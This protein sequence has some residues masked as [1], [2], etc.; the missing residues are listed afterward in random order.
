MEAGDLDFSGAVPIFRHQ[1][2]TLELRLG[3]ATASLQAEVGAKMEEMRDTFHPELE[4]VIVG[5]R[6][7]AIKSIKNDPGVEEGRIVKIEGVLE[8]FPIPQPG[9][10]LHYHWSRN[11]SSLMP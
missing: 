7:V 2:I 1:P 5:V 11:V 10:V 8:I 3:E 9:S 4:A 6:E